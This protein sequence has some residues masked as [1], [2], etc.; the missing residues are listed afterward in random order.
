MG[1]GKESFYDVLGIPTHASEAQIRQAFKRLALLHHPDKAKHAFRFHIIREAHEVLSNRDKRFIYDQVHDTI[2]PAE[3]EQLLISS[4]TAALS[5]SF[6]VTQRNKNR[7]FLPRK[8]ANGQT[9][10][11]SYRDLRQVENFFATMRSSLIEGSDVRADDLYDLSA[12]FVDYLK[13]GFSQTQCEEL[14]CLCL[15][16]SPG[17]EKPAASAIAAI[18]ECGLQTPFSVPCL[19]TAVTRLIRA[20]KEDAFIRCLAS[21][22]RV[23]IFRRMHR[24][25]VQHE[26]QERPKVHVCVL[27]NW[28][29]EARMVFS[30]GSSQQHKE[31]QA[32]YRAARSANAL[33]QCAYF[34]LDTIHLFDHSPLLKVNQMLQA[35]AL[36]HETQFVERKDE[37][38]IFA[39]EQMIIQVSHLLIQTTAKA[40]IFVRMYALQNTMCILNHLLF[41]HPELMIPLCLISMG[42]YDCLKIYPFLCFP[43]PSSELGIM[44]KQ[45]LH[46]FYLFLQSSPKQQLRIT[47]YLYSAWV[48]NWQPTT[49]DKSEESSLQLEF[50]SMLLKEKDWNLLDVLQNVHRNLH[51]S[52]QNHEGWFH[53][54][55]DS[56]SSYQNFNNNKQMFKAV[57]GFKIGPDGGLQ[58]LL[59]TF[60]PQRDAPSKA[61]LFPEDVAELTT[62]Q[63]E[64]VNFSLDPVVSSLHPCQEMVF[65]PS[66]LQGTNL[67]YA[68]LAADWRLKFLTMGV[69]IQSQL[70]FAT[71]PLDISFLPERLRS[72]VAEYYDTKPSDQVH[73]FW[74]DVQMTRCDMSKGEYSFGDTLV[75]L[76][77][78]QMQWEEDNGK[79][80]L[81]DLDNNRASEWRLV[82]LGKR[83][84]PVES[85]AKNAIIMESDDEV[86][87]FQVRF[88]EH[89]KLNMF[90]R[91]LQLS[92][93]YLAGLLAQPRDPVTHELLCTKQ[94]MHF[95]YSCVR[96][97]T[98]RLGRPHGFSP[99]RVFAEEFTLR[100]DEFAVFL[101][102]IDAPQTTGTRDACCEPAQNRLRRRPIGRHKPQGEKMQLGSGCSRAKKCK[103]ICGWW[104]A[105]GANTCFGLTETTASGIYV[106][107]AFQ[108][109]IWR[110]AQRLL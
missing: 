79:K 65:Q 75:S 36:L 41:E 80:K 92:P 84:T 99:A 72:V 48:Q 34:C 33:R 67:L 35:C 82:L 87:R 39:D 1:P 68:L 73:R 61:C 43:Q 106:A 90:A 21:L 69:E 32:Q 98:A 97:I 19:C 96:H 10:I 12:L 28:H 38:G 6:R 22:Y 64:E 58:L 24:L 4:D 108:R 105:L 8:R 3:E 60:D 63:L 50:M 2:R 17:D 81:V 49:L 70:P 44:S 25:A 110:Q 100:Y 78:N 107:L 93:T 30:E 54:N 71:R 23:K 20:L 40:N 95:M 85:V 9:H 76:F 29:F 31:L 45:T 91:K 27:D 94:N 42:I 7:Q 74:F 37:H 5:E 66:K 57:N 83:G 26:W 47:Q 56:M 109:S 62:L 77:T 89:G 15:S 53:S 46:A 16:W 52:F 13:T 11:H 102:G 88:L 18:I 51:V 104:R 14:R 86:G 59:E 103:P 55:A 101:P